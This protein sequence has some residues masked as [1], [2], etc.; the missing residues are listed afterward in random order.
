MQTIEGFETLNGRL[1]D[2]FLQ[3]TK[4]P[5]NSGICLIECFLG[6]FD[7]REFNTLLSMSACVFH[8]ADQAFAPSLGFTY[9]PAALG[10]AP[11]SNG[12]K[13]IN[14]ISRHDLGLPLQLHT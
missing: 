12:E 4:E 14:Q 8:K 10:C 2:K 5:F 3:Q 9:K 11:L 7:R 13:L 6:L 1:Y